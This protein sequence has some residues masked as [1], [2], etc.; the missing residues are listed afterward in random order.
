MGKVAG[1]V[2]RVPLLFDAVRVQDRDRVEEI[3]KE[4][5]QLEHDADLLKNEIRNNLPNS[6]FLPID[7]GNLL[8]IL[9]L[10]DSIADR[11]EDVAVLFTLR[12]IEPTQGMAPLLGPFVDKNI[13]T[14][15]E[16]AAIIREWQDLIESSFGGIEAEKVRQMTDAVAHTEHEVDVLQRQLLR[17]LYSSKE[18]DFQTFDLW[19]RILLEVGTIS[20]LSEKLANRIRMVLDLK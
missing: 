19:K 10:Q 3:A 20:N 4:V 16:V 17:E 9:S 13:E 7:R 2:E 8:D 1:C 15:R 12:P 11:A 14:F 5:C 18:L 6:L